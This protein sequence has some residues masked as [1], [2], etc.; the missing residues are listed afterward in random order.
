LIDDA[1]IIKTLVENLSLDIEVNKTIEKND[2]GFILIFKKLD[3]QR[4]FWKPKGR[5]AIC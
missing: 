5:N 4:L 3:A 1:P 2:E